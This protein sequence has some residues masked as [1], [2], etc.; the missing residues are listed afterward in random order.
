MT[1]LCFP[2]YIQGPLSTPRQGTLGPLHTEPG[3]LIAPALRGRPGPRWL[4]GV[5]DY[6]WKLDDIAGLLL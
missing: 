2:S 3:G 6:I 1:V 5:A 4:P